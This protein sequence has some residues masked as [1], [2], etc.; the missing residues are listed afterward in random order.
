MDERF[1]ESFR[2]GIVQDHP[3]Y[4]N[5]LPAYNYGDDCFRNAA[6]FFKRLSGYILS[7]MSSALQTL[8]L[9]GII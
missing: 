8:A 2:V 1:L 7:F 5:T 9:L 4:T 6:F 3:F